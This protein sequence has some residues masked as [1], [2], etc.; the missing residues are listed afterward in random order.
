MIYYD[1]LADFT[2]LKGAIC[3]AFGCHRNIYYILSNELW[4]FLGCISK[5]GG[6]S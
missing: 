6:E 5:L 4:R 2:T 1:F 3:V